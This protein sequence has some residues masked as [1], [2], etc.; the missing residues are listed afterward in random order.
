MEHNSSSV[1]PSERI[2]SLDVLRGAGIFGILLLNVPSIA[3]PSIASTN[4]SAYKYFTGADYIVWVLTHVFADQKFLAIFTILFGAGI[5]LF[6]DK[7]QGEHES[8]GRLHFKR[9]FWLLVFGL[10]HA[11][12]V[13]DGDI[14]AVY[15]M[16][17]FIVVFARNWEPIN[18]LLTG[19]GFIFITSLHDLAFVI[20]GNTEVLS[21]WDGDTVGIEREIAAYQSEWVVQVLY[22]APD[23]FTSHTVGFLAGTGWYLAGLM[24]IGMALYKYG[25]L[26]GDRSGVFYRQTSI[27]LITV[28]VS[29]TVAG[30]VFIEHAGWSRNAAVYWAEIDRFGSLLTAIGYITLLVYV[31]RVCSNTVTRVL[32]NV[33]RTALSNYILQS[34][35]ATSIFYGHGFGLI[36]TVSRVQLLGVILS[37]WL[38]QVILTELWLHRFNRG[39]LEQL[40][41]HLTY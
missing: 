2:T 17:G 23:V 9:M 19:I 24:L 8:P 11:Y 31:A 40:W 16:C 38:V 32:A 13:W 21:G 10:V 7:K 4:P 34:L 18:Q 35:I 22:R 15:A 5:V 12:I 6:M 3:L 14:L 36:G 33:G 41:R 37:I 30:V 25:V 28:G 20:Q 29:I 39:P 26:S 27:T 1:T